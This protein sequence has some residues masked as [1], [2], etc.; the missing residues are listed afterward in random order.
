MSLPNTLKIESFNTDNYLAN[1]SNLTE[2]KPLTGYR[3]VFSQNHEIAKPYCRIILDI[4]SLPSEYMRSAN[5]SVYF[6]TKI[7]SELDLM[8][9]KEVL[10]AQIISKSEYQ[11]LQKDDYYYIQYSYVRSGLANPSPVT[12]TTLWFYDIYYFYRVQIAYYENDKSFWEEDMQT[13]IKSIEFH[14]QHVVH[15]GNF[16]KN[17]LLVII[18]AISVV[19]HYVYK[20]NQSS[21]KKVEDPFDWGEIPSSETHEEEAA[22]VKVSEV[23]NTPNENPA[24]L[25]V[26]AAELEC[27]K[28]TSSIISLEKDTDNKVVYEEKKP[29]KILADLQV[30]SA[31]LEQESLPSLIYVGYSSPLIYYPEDTTCYP[32]SIFPEKGCVVWPYRKGAIARRGKTERVFQDILINKLGSKFNVFGDIC[33]TVQ[34]GCRPYEPDIAIIDNSD[35][36]IRI[37]IEIDEPYTGQSQIPTHYI[38]CG[39]DIRD[40][41]FSNIGWVVIRF[42]EISIINEPLNCAGFIAK[43]IRELNPNI[44]LS[45][46]LFNY[47]LPNIV[48]RW[49]KVESQRMSMQKYRE[50]YLKEEFGFTP[51]RIYSDKDLILSDFEAKCL[52]KIK[53][54]T[55][56][57]T[58]KDAQYVSFNNIN[59][60][61]R[62]T[63]IKYFAS[64]HTYLYKDSISFTSIGDLVNSFFPIFDSDKISKEMVKTSHIS[65][66]EL[67]ESWDITGCKARE[68]GIFMHEQIENILLRKT[69]T[70]SYQ[71][72]YKGKYS[73]IQESILINAE[74]SLL[75][76]FLM[77][78]KINL[79]RVGW[80]IFDEEFKIAGTIDLLSFDKGT[81]IMYD[82]KRSNK[83]IQVYSGSQFNI[84]NNL[85]QSALSGL[86]HLD[87]SPYNRYCLQQNIYRYILNKHYGISVDMMN[88]V[89]IHPDYIEPYVLQVPIMEK[90]VEFIINNL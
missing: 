30:S 85:S 16:S 48:K 60:N 50:S 6:T 65:S 64:S 3:V 88:L 77:S 43:I 57:E 33:L 74:I 24:T 59:A 53:Q 18:L 46:E 83:I 37:D 78:N 81:Y 34:N 47:P 1:K 4:D 22:E 72:V 58:P 66:D 12:V 5:N 67:I 14:P 68:V 56:N 62:D 84:C 10:P 61:T 42:A 75:Y 19:L 71:F 80:K 39:D 38:G 49:S 90:E 7:K 45:E 28:A 54:V 52:P 23:V 55:L 51:T 86:S 79:Y 32:V 13:V 89:I 31:Y 41:H 44:S 69:I 2:G 9:R 73:N 11:C 25:S 26:S 40:L 21:K 35:F 20:K 36:N 76:K 17:V 87:N 82:W 29:T 8:I 15:N 70:M 63:E 27:K